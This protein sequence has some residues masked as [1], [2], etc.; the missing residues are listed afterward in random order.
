M[1]SHLHCT[2]CPSLKFN[3]CEH[4]TWADISSRLWR[5][6]KDFNWPINSSCLNWPLKWSL[7]AFS[8]YLHR[9]GQP[10]NQLHKDDISPL[11]GQILYLTTAYTWSTFFKHFSATSFKFYTHAKNQIVSVFAC[12]CFVDQEWKYL[13]HWVSYIREFNYR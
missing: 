4:E 3:Y 12:I 5:C 8:I 13:G 1:L 10:I 7:Y 9:V 6:R 2:V 11:R